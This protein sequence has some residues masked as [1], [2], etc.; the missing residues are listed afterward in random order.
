MNGSNDSPGRVNGDLE[1]LCRLLYTVEA[2]MYERGQWYDMGKPL[3]FY[4][5]EDLMDLFS[6]PSTRNTVCDL[7]INCYVS[8]YSEFWTYWPYFGT[9]YEEWKQVRLT[10]LR[11]KDR[12][13]NEVR[14]EAPAEKPVRKVPEAPAPKKQKQKEPA[15]KVST[16]SKG[17]IMYEVRVNGKVEATFSFKTKAESMKRSLKAKGLNARIFVVFA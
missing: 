14:A 16:P 5:A 10:L 11:M 17:Q 15:K 7:F 9:T 6:D 1:A 13:S 8:H 3:P 4:S 12:S 2:K